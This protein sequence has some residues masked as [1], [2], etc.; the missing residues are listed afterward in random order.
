MRDARVR[1]DEPEYAPGKVIG[2]AVGGRWLVVRNRRVFSSAEGAVWGQLREGDLWEM[3]MVPGLGPTHTFVVDAQNIYWVATPSG[4]LGRTPLPEG[5]D[6]RLVVDPG[7]KRAG[8]V[9]ASDGVTAFWRVD[10]AVVAAPLAGGALRT[11]AP[12]DDDGPLVVTGGVVFHAAGGGVARVA[13]DGSGA[14]P[15]AADQGRV[16]ALGTDGQRIAWVNADGAVRVAPASGGP[17]TELATGV[18]GVTGLA[19]GGDGVYLS[20]ATSLLRVPHAG[21]AP[22]VVVAKAGA[23]VA[24]VVDGGELFWIDTR[25]NLVYARR[26]GS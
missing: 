13:A 7:G 23:P 25:E 8:R 20:T 19:V 14:A 22:E 10:G 12:S 18:A 16:I 21:G 2:T 5:G 17:V 11:L 6:P 4:G 9:L 1:S 26:L 15:L 3:A 24:P